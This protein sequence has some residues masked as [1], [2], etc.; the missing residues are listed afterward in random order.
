MIKF[1]LYKQLYGENMVS[2]CCKKEMEVVICD[3]N[4]WYY[5]C[6]E[7]ERPCDG[8]YPD[9]VGEYDHE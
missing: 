4:S 9:L 8:F 2:R 6:S 3:S 1:E 5:L 7:C